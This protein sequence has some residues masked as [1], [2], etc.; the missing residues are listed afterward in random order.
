MKDYIKKSVILPRV[1]SKLIRLAIHDA[2][3]SLEQGLEIDMGSWG[4]EEDC[5]V[6]FAGGVILQSCT[7]ERWKKD[8]S[9]LG[10]LYP[11]KHEKNE[12]QLIFLNSISIGQLLDAMEWLGLEDQ[13][14]NKYRNGT[15]VENKTGWK[16][17]HQCSDPQEFFDQCE[18]L[19]EYLES[20]GN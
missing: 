12:D 20:T 18:E 11:Y 15:W 3:L 7:K 16:Y 13:T 14:I 5:T 9:I 17:Y 4:D 6:C 10:D 19:A 8:R 1:P 2:K